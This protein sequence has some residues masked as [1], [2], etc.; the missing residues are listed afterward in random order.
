MSS[1]TPHSVV[2]TSASFAWPDGS[3]VLDS[4]SAA[5]GTGRTGIVGENGV[6]KTTILRLI[7]GSMVP[8]AGSVWVTGAV[9]HLPQQLSLRTETTVADL[10]GVR[11]P[12]DALHA[13]EAGD[14]DPAL[15]DAVG[16]L[17]DVESRSEAVL[18]AAGLGAIGLDR[19]VGTLSGGETVLIALA[20]LKLA[21]TPIVLLDEPTNNLDRAARA[22]LYDTISAWQRTLIVVSHD[23]QLLELMD[24]TAELRAG[25]L[26]L[27]GGP[28]SAFRAHL[29]GEQAA[30]E[31]ALRTA[32]Q[33][34]STER[35]QRI[36]AETKL[37]R[38][39]RYAKTDFENKRKP[40]IVMKQRATEAQ[41]SAGKLRGEMEDRTEAAQQRVE[42]AAARVR[43][44]PKIHIDLPDPD[45]PAGRRLAELQ[46]SDRPLLIQ[47]PER[48]ALMGVN[49][50][51]KT[52]LLEE[53][54]AST[55]GRAVLHTRRVGYLPQRLNHLD[56][57]AT[58]ID[59]VRHVAPHQASGALRAK[60]ARF[61]FRGDSVER[62]VGSLS[63]GERF[64][65]ALARLL[66]A[67]PPNQL[68]ILDE[69]TNNL[70][71]STIDVL[72]DALDAYRGGIVVVSHDDVFLARLGIDIWANLNGDGLQFGTTPPTEQKTL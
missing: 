72:V 51:G 45:V 29:A 61:L 55:P 58:V 41:V 46:A 12:L 9:G 70:D 62:P 68:L 10:L 63:G 13:I 11:V 37:A 38:R 36:E 50:I 7:A 44:D 19:R 31:Q 22:R 49:G 18:G 3:P 39:S 66:L 54:I 35:R 26:T 6:G 71:L 17:W 8:S 21:D 20:G 40:K 67:D 43:R 53:L 65:V 42:A 25:R 47:G 15:F 1:A 32:E 16:E 48:V 4:V 2:F 14:T 60:L 24:D 23:V 57:E 64:R 5:F 69:P 34:F 59:S 33:A 30:A 52:R 56:D 27:F 28:Y